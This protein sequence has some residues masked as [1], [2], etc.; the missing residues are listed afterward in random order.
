MVKRADPLGV[1]KVNVATE[2]KIVLADAVKAT[3]P[4]S[5]N[6]PAQIYRPRQVG[7]MK[8]VVAEKISACSGML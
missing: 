4:A 7:A 1:C 5:D 3:F 6:D 2:L 8:E